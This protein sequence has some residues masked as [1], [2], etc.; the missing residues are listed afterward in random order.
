MKTDLMTLMSKK[1]AYLG[2]QSQ[3]TAENISK[4]DIPGYNRKELKSFQD[5]MNHSHEKNRELQIK[6][7]DVIQTKESV[8]ADWE[9]FDMTMTSMDHQAMVNMYSK[10]LGMFKAIFGKNA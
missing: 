1:I 6:K 3:V 9:S 8:S 4:A 10:Y 5:I 2:A 7:S